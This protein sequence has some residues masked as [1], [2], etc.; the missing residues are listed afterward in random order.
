MITLYLA[1]VLVLN[2]HLCSALSVEVVKSN[3]RDPEA[4]IVFIP[5]KDIHGDRYIPLGK[6]K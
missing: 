4:A 2:A 3:C 1:T 5:A 6:V